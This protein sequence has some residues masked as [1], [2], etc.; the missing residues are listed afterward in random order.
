MSK[1][2]SQAERILSA[3][4]TWCELER[5]RSIHIE[6]PHTGRLLVQ[7][8]ARADVIE[9]T[10]EDLRDALAQIAQVVQ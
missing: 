1:M 4:A 5:G 3:L 7:L 2:N 10:G 9:C 6:N 8:T